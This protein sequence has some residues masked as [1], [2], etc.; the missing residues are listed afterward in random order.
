MELTSKNVERIFLDC[1]YNEESG[2]NFIKVEGVV[3]TFGF[4][5]E[6]LEKNKQEIYDL[7]NELPD[8]FKTS[9]AGGM[10]FLNACIDKNGVQW[11]EHMN[12]EELF[13]LGIGVELVTLPLSKKMWGMLPGA[14]PYYT[15]IDKE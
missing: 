11:G 14:M 7:L 15:F 8:G 1:L 4:N 10:S 13:C 3:H 5:Q 9:G 2:E 12:M 6:R